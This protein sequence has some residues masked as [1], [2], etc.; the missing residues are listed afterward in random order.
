MKRTE[1]I[2]ELLREFKRTAGEKYGIE[3]LALFG[4]AARGEQREDSDIDIC[5]KLRKTTFRIYNAI[6]EDLEHLFQLKVDLLTL[7]ENMRQ[8]FRQN[9]ERDAIYI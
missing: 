5:V 1:E 8:L 7:H 4:S 6:K 3:Q 2:I 9:I